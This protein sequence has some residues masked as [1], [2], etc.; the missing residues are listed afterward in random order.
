MRSQ[1]ALFIGIFLVAIGLFFLLGVIFNFNAWA[2][3]WPI[4]LIALG[5]FL[6]LRP[7]WL[8]ADTA[9][10]QK[11]VGDIRRDGVWNVTDE[12]MWL[13]V[14]DIK[15]DLTRAKIPAGETRLR[16][17]SFVGDVDVL[18]PA[19]VGIS[20]SAQGFLTEAKLFGQKRESFFAPIHFSSD[21][22]EVAERKIRLEVVHFVG[23]VEL[24]RVE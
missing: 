17:F 15:L 24:R 13:F 16:I 22:Y 1:G 14:G 7:R 11:F 21:D 20:L 10:Q 2:Y 6:L 19:G 23:D 5:I 8:S 9:V 4:G 18:L 12:E 3:C